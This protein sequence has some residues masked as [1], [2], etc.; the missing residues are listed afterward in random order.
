MKIMRRYWMAT[1][2]TGERLRIPIV[3]RGRPCLYTAR[4]RRLARHRYQESKRAR[5]R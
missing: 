3:R 5:Q 1:L 2:S 4:E